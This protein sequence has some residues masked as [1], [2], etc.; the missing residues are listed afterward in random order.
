MC[1][2]DLGGDKKMVRCTQ[3][4]HKGSGLK[5]I[6]VSDDLCCELGLKPGVGA[7]IT[8]N[9]GNHNPKDMREFAKQWQSGDHTISVNGMMYPRASIKTGLVTVTIATLKAFRWTCY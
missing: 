4:V 3:V 8:V 7:H 6:L 2:S 9:P 5:V 1:S